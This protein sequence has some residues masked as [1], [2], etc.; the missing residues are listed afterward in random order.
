MPLHKTNPERTQKN[1]GYLLITWVDNVGYAELFDSSNTFF[2]YA[3]HY[4]KLS[5]DIAH[6][7]SSILFCILFMKDLLI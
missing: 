2:I 7:I 6:R 5:L 1:S 4:L 3:D